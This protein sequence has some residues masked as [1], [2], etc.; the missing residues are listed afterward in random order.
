MD[1]MSQGQCPAELQRGGDAPVHVALSDKRGEDYKEPPPPSYVK[2]S[3]EG[4]SLSGASSSAAAAAPVQSDAGSV[5]V[6][7]SKPKTKVQ[8][9]F[10]DGQRKVQEFNEDHTIGDLRTFC[11]Q[12]AGGVAMTVMGGFP[13]KPLSDDAQ[14]LKDA[15][16]VGAA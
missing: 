15:G 12:C 7:A 11:S 8:I 16:L 13:P 5:A 9:R 2:F 14:T 1:E 6:D 4:N 3:G 10:H